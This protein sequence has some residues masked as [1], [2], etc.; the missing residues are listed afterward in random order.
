MSGED[1]IDEIR[2][3]AVRG[4]LA[5]EWFAINGPADAQPLPL[6]HDEREK[7]KV[8]G[9]E[10]LVAWYDRSL[11]C[12]DYDTEKHP[13]FDDYAPGVMAS[14]HAP[15]FIKN[16]E[17]L[18]RRYPPKKLIGLGPGLVWELPTPHAETMCTLAPQ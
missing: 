3:K 14:E 7:M 13:S 9:V 1:P 2:E 16:D 5:R 12:R 6:S 4:L 17:Q 8:G 11:A 15:D 18:R 10:H